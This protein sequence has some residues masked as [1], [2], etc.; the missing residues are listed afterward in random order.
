[1]L[2]EGGSVAMLENSLASYGT[3]LSSTGTIN[4]MSLEGYLSA[5]G[6]DE[7]FS[8]PKYANNIENW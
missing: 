1:M 3:S 8:Q 7:V 5:N 6:I 4:I 2:R